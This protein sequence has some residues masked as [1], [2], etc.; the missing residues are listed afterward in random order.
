MENK[1]YVKEWFVYSEI[2]EYGTYTKTYARACQIQR[3]LKIKGGVDAKIE[4][5]PY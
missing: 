5:D 4:Y 1:N 3:D 2:L